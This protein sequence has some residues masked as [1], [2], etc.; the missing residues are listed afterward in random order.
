LYWD[1]P[2]PDGLG[3]FDIWMA[4]RAFVGAPFGPA[5]NLGPPVNS[6]GPDFG[7]AIS[8]NE[9][10]LFFS[11]GRPG[12]VGDVDIWVVERRRKEDSWGIPINVETL[13]SPFFQLAPSFGR[14]GRDVCFMSFRPTGLGDIDV[15]CA[16]RLN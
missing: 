10:R 16:T 2:R 5:V 1:S 4:R 11:S 3:D 8:Q 15:W 7:V 13:N 12:N 14:N 6:E 9:R